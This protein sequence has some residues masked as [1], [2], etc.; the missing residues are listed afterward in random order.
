MFRGRWLLA[1][2]VILCREL[3]GKSGEQPRHIF[4]NSGKDSV[5]NL[6]AAV[7]VGGFYDCWSCKKVRWKLKHLNIM[8]TVVFRFSAS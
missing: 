1:R 8:Q 2:I 7:L 6:V 4:E 5:V 3:I